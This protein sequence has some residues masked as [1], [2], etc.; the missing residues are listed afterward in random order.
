M[1]TVGPNYKDYPDSQQNKEA[2][3][4]NSLRTC[5][6]TLLDSMRSMQIKRIAIPPIATEGYFGFPM[7]LCARYIIQAIIE[8]TMARKK[9]LEQGDIEEITLIQPDREQH[10]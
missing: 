7:K 1:F 8:W 4:R 10:L 6:Y 2:V 3:M 5:V 9:E